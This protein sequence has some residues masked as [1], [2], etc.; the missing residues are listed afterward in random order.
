[1]NSKILCGERPIVRVF[2]FLEKSAKIFY[3]FR[4][5]SRVIFDVEVPGGHC[6]SSIR[7]P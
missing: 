3:T 5:V 4:K 6:S 7:D 1:M 2:L